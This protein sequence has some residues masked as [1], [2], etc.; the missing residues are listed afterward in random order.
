MATESASDV[1]SGTGRKTGKEAGRTTHVTHA[2]GL[3][4]PLSETLSPARACSTT[5][6]VASGSAASRYFLR[7]GQ[8]GRWTARRGSSGRAS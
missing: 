3:T 6:A 2:F 7:P 5:A 4:L 8:S 1:Q